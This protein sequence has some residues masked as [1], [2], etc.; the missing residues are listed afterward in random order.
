V[1]EHL[2]DKAIQEICRVTRH[3]VFFGSIARDFGNQVVRKYDLFYG[4]TN[5]LT[6][7]EWSEVFLR[8]GFRL[9]IEE[10]EALA[11]A[12]KIERAAC[13]DEKWY[14]SAES[15][16]YCF[17]TKIR[18]AQIIELPGNNDNAVATHTSDA[19]EEEPA[20]TMSSK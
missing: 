4:M 9:A 5:V 16:R 18:N 11:R 3:G 14:R 8:N 2:R 17:Y 6:M 1:P 13:G 10:P 15:M 12:W 20:L 7:K 19:P